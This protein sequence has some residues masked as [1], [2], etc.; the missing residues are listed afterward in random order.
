MAKNIYNIEFPPITLPSGKVIAFTSLCFR[1]RRNLLKNYKRE[2]GYLLE[3][4]LAAYALSKEDGNPVHDPIED[5]GV[6]RDE[7]GMT[8]MS[9]LVDRMNH[10]SLKDCQ[11]YIEI[12]MRI[13]G[14]DEQEKI[15]AEE[16]AKKLMAGT[17]SSTP[18]TS[19]TQTGLP[20]GLKVNTGGT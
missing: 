17:P 1:D 19:G 7:N 20:K 9:N 13:V 16:V 15:N 12:L 8:A 5:L 11:Y 10:W 3:E 2:E 14:L 4:L 18:Q 6:I